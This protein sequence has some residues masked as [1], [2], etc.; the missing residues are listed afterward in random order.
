MRRISTQ[1]LLRESIDE[2]GRFTLERKRGVP[3][4]DHSLSG[5]TRG[6]SKMVKLKVASPSKRG[7]SS[8]KLVKE[9]R[10]E[11]GAISQKERK[12]ITDF[13]YRDRQ[14][15]ANAIVPATQRH[16]F[17]GMATLAEKKTRAALEARGEFGVHTGYIIGEPVMDSERQRITL[18]YSTEN[19]LLNAYRQS[20]YGIPQLVQV[21]CTHRLMLEGHNCMLFGCVDAAQHFHT[22]GYGVCDS[23]DCEAHTTVFY[24]LKSEV[25]RI[26]AARIEAQIPI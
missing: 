4:T 13:A 25:E 2:E 24:A 19:L 14:K 17:G 20:Q 1:A 10:N 7:R 6:L 8:H 9:L 18:A 16:R 21:D 23:E 3:H 26:V 15:G 22:I 5:K 11:L 12:Q